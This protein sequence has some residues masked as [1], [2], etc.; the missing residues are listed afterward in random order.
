[1]R[2]DTNKSRVAAL[3][4]ALVLGLLVAG[5]VQPVG[6]ASIAFA[7]L[8]SST[9]KTTFSVAPDDDFEIDII[10]VDFD[11]QTLSGGEFFIEYDRS[12]LTIRSVTIDQ[13]WGY[14]P[15]V[16]DDE[17]EDGRWGLV[18]FDYERDFDASS[19]GADAWSAVGFDLFAA[20]P[21]SGD[22][23]IA[24]ISFTAS[25]AFG[26]GNLRIVES[27]FYADG[28]VPTGF[29]AQ[30]LS[31]I[32]PTIVDAVISVVPIPGT[33]WLMLTAVAGVACRA[34]RRPRRAA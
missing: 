21:G 25:D 4:G 22:F 1:M 9:P 15:S 18:G 11:T 29:A 19:A 27:V 8:N 14:L 5:V 17:D 10:G 24:T 31:E 26:A 3:L 23:R 34:I 32:E 30:D 13:R 6:A 2:N 16:G 20:L 33:L 7:D 12:L 28:V